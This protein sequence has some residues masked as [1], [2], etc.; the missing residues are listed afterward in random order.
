GGQ[1]GEWTRPLLPLAALLIVAFGSLLAWVGTAEADPAAD[2]PLLAE[3]LMPDPLVL[4]VQAD[5]RLTLDEIV[6][7]LEGVER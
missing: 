5:A 3:V 1:V 4:W 7:V 6:E 2:A